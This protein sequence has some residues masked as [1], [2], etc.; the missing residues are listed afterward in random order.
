FLAV[1]FSDE[2]VLP[3]E[4]SQFQQFLKDELDKFRK[5]TNS[6]M[7]L[8][9]ELDSIQ[10]DD[11]HR[12]EQIWLDV[13]NGARKIY[14]VFREYVAPMVW[15]LSRDCQRHQYRV[16]LQCGRAFDDELP[17]NSRQKVSEATEKLDAAIVG[18]LKSGLPIDDRFLAQ[19]CLPLVYQQDANANRSTCDSILLISNALIRVYLKETVCGE[20]LPGHQYHVT[21]DHCGDLIEESML[22]P[23]APFMLDRGHAGFF[24]VD[25]DSRAEAMTLSVA[26]HRSLHGFSLELRRRRLIELM[27]MPGGRAQSSSDDG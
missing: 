10:A 26:I 25:P 21:R 12:L 15:Q 5:M 6:A 4:S 23:C 1:L 19:H 11:G 16:L 9:C 8:Y 14:R 24:V 22:Q 7:H 3:D 20:P 27:T 17:E 13:A 18:H 2:E